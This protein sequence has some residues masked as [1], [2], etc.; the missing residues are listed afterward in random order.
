MQARL[1]V[2][3]AYEVPALDAKGHLATHIVIS[4][5]LLDERSELV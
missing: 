3:D 5:G 2:E 1:L 4:R